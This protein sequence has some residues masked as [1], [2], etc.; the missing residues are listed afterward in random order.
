MS[1]STLSPSCGG[2]HAAVIELRLNPLPTRGEGRVRGSFSPYESHKTGKVI[3]TH[4]Y[5]NIANTVQYI[6]FSLYNYP[7]GWIINSATYQN[8]NPFYIGLAYNIL[9]GSEV[10]CFFFIQP[11]PTHCLDLNLFTPGFVDE[12]ITHIY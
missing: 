4:A 7:L 11:A 2:S 10:L 6:H 12:E 9:I 3:S 8:H 5:P 1:I